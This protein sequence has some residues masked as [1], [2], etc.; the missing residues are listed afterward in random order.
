MDEKGFWSFEERGRERE[1]ELQPGGKVEF[2][3]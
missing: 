3:K 2:L 1:R